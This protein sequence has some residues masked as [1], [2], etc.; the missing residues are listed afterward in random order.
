M[1]PP[2]LG[3]IL[4]TTPIESVSAETPPVCTTTSSTLYGLAMKDTELYW[5][6]KL[7]PSWRWLIALLP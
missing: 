3:I 2:S 7:V 5:V 4:I 1:L 6:S